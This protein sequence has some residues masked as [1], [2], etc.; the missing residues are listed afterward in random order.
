MIIHKDGST[1][2]WSMYSGRSAAQHVF[3]AEVIAISGA[4]ADHQGWVIRSS[5]A[6]SSW[7]RVRDTTAS[8]AQFL[9]LPPSLQLLSTTH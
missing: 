5:I 4:A 7:Y 9:V 1:H 6:I 2:V 8:R 3:L